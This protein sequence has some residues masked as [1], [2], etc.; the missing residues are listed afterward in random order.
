MVCVTLKGLWMIADRIVDFR[1]FIT[2]HKSGPAKIFSFWNTKEH[3]SKASKKLLIK[4]KTSSTWWMLLW[5][6]YGWFLIE[7]SIFDFVFNFHRSGPTKIFNFWTT[8]VHVSYTSK[9]LLMKQKTSGCVTLEGLW[10]ISDRFIDF[11]FFVKIHRSGPA[12]I[13]RFWSIT[14]DLSYASKQLLI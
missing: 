13:F 3:V 6:Y 11:R 10:L 4:V 2:F 8:T 14:E 12:I 1:C 9:K 5:K 7:L